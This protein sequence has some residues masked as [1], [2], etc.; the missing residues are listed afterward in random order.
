MF[1]SAQQRPQYT[2][3]I[4]N[5][6]LLN[7]AISGIENYLDFKA[8]FRKQWAGI[9]NSPQTNFVSAHWKLGSDYLWKNPLSLPEKEENPMGRNYMQNYTASPA[10]HGMGIIAVMD[11]AG[12]LSRL[13][14]GLTYAYHLQLSDNYNLSVGVGAGIS[15]IA[16]DASALTLENP[17]DPA[18]SNAVS[19]QIK[20]DLSVGL[21]LYGARLFA[22][23]SVQ[24]LLPQKLAFTESANLS[25]GRAVPH[26]FFT[27]GYKLFIDEEIAVV[28][29][30][31]VKKVS[32]TPLSFDSNVKVSF[33][34]RFWVG[35][36]YRKGDSYAAMAGVNISKL[37]NVTYS[38]DLT[39]S[40]L[41][42]VSNGS[43]EIVLGLQLNNVYNAFSS[44]RIW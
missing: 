8:G 32:A 12:P 16:L 27:T 41:N 21:W 39:T 18:L 5:N 36:S 42:T 17:N 35:A 31:M 6:Y 29:S 33:K 19:S 23:V 11:K 15:R 38:Y 13:D 10:H 34:D 2:Q 24:Q 37:F 1:T 26:L 22:G 44:M 4:F 43:H 30:M 7:P 3:Y 28:P 9:E 40:A 14:A 20:P 25:K